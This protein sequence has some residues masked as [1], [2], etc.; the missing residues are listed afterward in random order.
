MIPSGKKKEKLQ[1]TTNSLINDGSI[2]VFAIMPFLILERFLGWINS[3]MSVNGG[4]GHVEAFLLSARVW[5][6]R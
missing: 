3:E 6:L 1:F 2:G 4:N 5:H